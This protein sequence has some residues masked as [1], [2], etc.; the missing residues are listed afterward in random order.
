MLDGLEIL[1][2]LHGTQIHRDDGYWYKIEA[3]IIPVT[4]HTP[5]G[6]RYNMTLHDKHNQR[7]FGHD[8]KHMVQTGRKANYI[9][10]RYE[11]DHVHKSIN[12]KG[13]PYEFTTCYK[14]I[15]DFFNGIDLTIKE[16]E[17]K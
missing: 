3:W 16:I 11:Y 17:G 8:N 10:K 7:V 6:I 14:L 4:K 9:G 2:D 12:D 15:E 1:L 13:T 5:H